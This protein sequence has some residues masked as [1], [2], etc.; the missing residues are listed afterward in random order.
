MKFKVGDFVI[1]IPEARVTGYIYKVLK[2]CEEIGTIQLFNVNKNKLSRL[3][4]NE[5]YLIKNFQ[6]ASE[7]EIAEALVERLKR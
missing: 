5:D 7:D 6:L 2:V 1:A 4:D 3:Y